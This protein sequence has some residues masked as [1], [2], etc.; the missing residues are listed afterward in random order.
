MGA[1]RA[2]RAGPGLVVQISWTGGM[3]GTVGMAYY[4]DNSAAMGLVRRDWRV[5]ALAA[6]LLALPCVP[7]ISQATES[8]RWLHSQHKLEE[9]SQVLQRRAMHC[10]SPLLLQT[11]LHVSRTTQQLDFRFEPSRTN[12]QY[13]R[14]GEGVPMPRPRRNPR[15]TARLRARVMLSVGDRGPARRVRGARQVPFRWRTVRT[16]G[17]HKR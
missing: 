13:R 8:I 10:A 6:W 15:S 4:L 9:T 11:E 16:S 12:V 7:L 1:A 14:R 17:R 3:V 2:A 5:K